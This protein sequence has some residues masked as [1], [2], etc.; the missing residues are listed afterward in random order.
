MALNEAY[1]LIPKTGEYITLHCK[2][3]FAGAIKVMNFEMRGLP[4]IN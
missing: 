1:V 4:W 3:D 2:R